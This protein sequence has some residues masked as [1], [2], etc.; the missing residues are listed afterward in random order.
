MPK[1]TANTDRRRTGRGDNIR[2]SVSAKANL[3]DQRTK[4]KYAPKIASASSEF[5]AGMKSTRPPTAGVASGTSKKRA[6]PAVR[7][8]GEK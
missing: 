5:S 4:G 7:K 2:T 6:A 1:A 8:L 3:Q